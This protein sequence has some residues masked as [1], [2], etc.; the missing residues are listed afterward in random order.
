M[1]SALNAALLIATIVLCQ[2][3]FARNARHPL[4]APRFPEAALGFLKQFRPDGAIF[5]DCLWGG[6][7]AYNAPHLAVFIDSR[8]DIFERNGTLKDYLDIIELKN[9]LS[10]LD[11]HQVR[12]VL[13]EKDAPLVYLL[14][15]TN[16]WQSLYDDGSTILLEHSNPGLALQRNA[17]VLK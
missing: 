9:S 13:F 11:K 5:N 8:F 4:A 15:Q 12:Y 16:H 3:H 6:Y 10:L 17:A 2:V 14:E 7:L 1:R